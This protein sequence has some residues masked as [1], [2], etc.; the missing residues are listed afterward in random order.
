MKI[1]RG[2]PVPV[3]V[4]FLAALFVIGSIFAVQSA[5]AETASE[6]C[7]QFPSGSKRNACIDGTKSGFDC[8]DYAITFGESTANVCRQAKKAKQD[9]IINGVP[10]TPSSTPVQTNNPCKGLTGDLLDACSGGIENKTCNEGVAII[11]LRMYNACALGAGI[12]TKSDPPRNQTRPSPSP[13]ASPKP[14]S[15]YESSACYGLAG[16]LLDA[17][18]GGA[19]YK[20]CNPNVGKVDLQLYQACALGAGLPVKDKYD[21]KTPATPAENFENFFQIQ[22]KL[23]QAKSLSEYTDALHQGGQDADKDLSE[24]P[25][26]NYG[27]YVNGA[28]KLQ[29]INVF[30]CA[31]TPP[32][33]ALIWFNGGGWHADDDVAKKIAEGS[34]FTTNNDPNAG[35]PAG[36]GGVARGYTIFDAKYRLGSDGIYYQFEDVMRATQHVVNNADMYGV[37]VN[38]IAIGGDSAG[39]SLAMRAAATGKTG[40]KAAVGWSAPTNAYTAIFNSFDAFAIGLD[41]STCVPTDLAGL[42]NTLDLLAGGSGDVAEEGKGISSNDFSNL[43]ITQ[44]I[45]GIGFDQSKFGADGVGATVLDVFTAVMYVSSSASSLESISSQIQAGGISSL[46]GGLMNLSSKK[47]VECIDNLNSASPALFASPETPATLL[48]G[49]TTD[50]IINPSQAYEMRDKLRGLG[51]RSDALLL[52]GDSSQQTNPLGPTPGNHL[53]YAPIFVC[54]TFSFLDEIMQPD[55]GVVN[56]ETGIPEGGPPVAASGGSS[57]GGGSGGG[58][59]QTSGGNGANVNSGGGGASSPSNGGS[60]VTP[61]GGQGQTQ[62][63]SG[64]SGCPSGVWRTTSKGGVYCV[65][66]SSAEQS[67]GYYA[68]SYSR[69][70]TR[71]T[72]PKGGTYT[73]RYAPANNAAVCKL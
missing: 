8:N 59:T 27:K 51:I 65:R 34:S 16:S 47:L 67:A 29:N 22:D 70:E 33:P 60:G 32:C 26:N 19:V 23:D 44:G 28:G 54:P 14:N 36:G 18:N 35:P 30:P 40:A 1:A 4:M 66:P 45:Y 48:A 17:C 50:D 63:N 21:L 25:D 62:T 13:S 11:D 38:K 3:R 41:H 58:G 56:C 49:Y 15:D 10:S 61:K 43:G 5:S 24:I 46:S 69:E 55:K 6:Y 7:S 52:E 2:I 53:D 37:D 9:G 39:G 20:Q 68:P 12:P 71:Y 73:Q 72:C 64:G 31:G 57:G 42:T